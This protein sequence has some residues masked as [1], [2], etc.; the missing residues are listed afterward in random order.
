[1]P[2]KTAADFKYHA[3]FAKVCRCV[4]VSPKVNRFSSK[5]SID[6]LKTILPAKI[7]ENG[8]EDLLPIAGNACVVNYANKNGDVIDTMTALAVYKNFARKYINIEHDR[9]SVIG[10]IENSSFSKF[11]PSYS[12]GA[13]SEPLTE[14]EASE[15]K[16]P[17]NIA[18]SGYIWTVVA[19]GVA[20]KILECNDP[21][22]PQYL[23]LSISWEIGFDNYQVAIGP[24][25]LAECEIISDAV[26]VQELSKYLKGACDEEGNLLPSATGQLDDGR[27]IYRLIGG[28]DAGVVPLGIGL[29]FAPAAAVAG[30]IAPDFQAKATEI[31]NKVSQLEA[32]NVIITNKTNTPLSMKVIKNL[33]DLRGLNDETAKEFSFAN[34]ASILDTKQLLAEVDIASVVAEYQRKLDDEKKAKDDALNSAVQ[35]A[36]AATEK[37]NDLQKEN[38]GFKK[39]LEDLQRSQAQ[40]EATT[41]FNDRM[42]NIDEQYELDDN[43]RASVAEDIRGLSDEDFDKWA[44]RFANYASKNKKTV[45][46]EDPA[47]VIETAVSNASKNVS[48]ASSEVPNGPAVTQTLIEKHRAAFGGDNIVVSANPRRK[49]AN[50]K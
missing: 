5:A 27:F 41:K 29:T 17:F 36:A 12:I 19:P 30:I 31:K 35:A 8:F 15:M 34:I 21:D 22:S 50:A 39:T 28:A 33:S 38:D 47:V 7:T 32:T 20:E 45:V 13:G 49:V 26:Q 43:M 3:T 2:K 40:A 14:A 24:Q 48:S 6:D 11:D 23:D 4:V 16:D 37:I 1:M 25:S 44:K 9:N 46:Q 42:Q 10:V 18:I